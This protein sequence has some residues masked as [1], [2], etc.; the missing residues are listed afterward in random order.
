M[1]V[2][3]LIE[4]TS[5]QFFMVE[6]F[7]NELKMNIYFC[8]SV[9]C[10]HTTGR[11]FVDDVCDPK[12]FYI[13]NS[14]GMTL[15]FGNHLNNE[16]NE[17]ILKYLSNETRERSKD[18]WLQIDPAEWKDVLMPLLEKG[19]AECHTR[20]NFKFDKEKYKKLKIDKTKFNIVETSK[21]MFYGITGSVVPKYF[22]INAELFVSL[23]KGFSIIDGGKIASTAYS[24]FVH[25]DKLEIGIET[26]EEFRGKGYAL[27]VSCA[28]IDYCIE[29]ELEPVWSC[30]LNNAG[31][32]Y[33]AQKL[34]F[35]PTIQ[36]PY[37]HILT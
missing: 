23:G 6:K 31:S 19:K 28:L 2:S 17:G 32:M 1:G 21:E 8:K 29:N 22:W 12:S 7:L 36:I 13:I 34:G 15:L 24:S 25:D 35:I 26:M 33:L 11:I 14:Y 27:A 20:Q 16:F 3:F 18:E 9:T 37:F 30:R 5:E 4:L 10:H